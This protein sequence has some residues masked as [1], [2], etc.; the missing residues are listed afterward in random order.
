MKNIIKFIFGL[1]LC[2][3]MFILNSCSDNK[4]D[5]SLP[6][7]PV[8]API[9]AATA[10]AANGRWTYSADIDNSSRTVTF[11]LTKAKPSELKSVKVVLSVSK[12]ATLKTP[13]DTVLTL[14]L[15][16]PLSITLNNLYKDVTYTMTAAIPEIV[17]CDKTL[18]KEHRLTNDSPAAVASNIKIE[19]LWDNAYMTKPNDYG[20]ISYHCYQTN[21]CFTVDLGDYYHLQK[22]LANWYWPL[23]NICPKKY[24]LLGYLGD[25]E[26]PVAGT[27]S[28][29]TVLA[30]IDNTGAT[31]DQFADGDAVEFTKDKAP[32]CRYIR[33]RCLENYR[34]PPST[35]LAFCEITFWAWNI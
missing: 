7:N 1:F 20:S 28:D 11:N 4:M 19:F 21:E 5:E 8:I 29:W 12:R 15:T 18:F 26:P 24:Q 22:F 10:T 23:S 17:K 14:D 2:L 3:G 35:I 13:T 27:W 30:N 25:G 9:K 32:Y 34:T 31:L 16:Q 33:V 6:L